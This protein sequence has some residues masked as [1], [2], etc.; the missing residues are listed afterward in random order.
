MKLQICI[1]TQ[2]LWN[3]EKVSLRTLI[4]NEKTQDIRNERERY[5]QKLHQIY[6]KGKHAQRPISNQQSSKDLEKDKKSGQMLWLLQ[7][8]IF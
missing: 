1:Q 6:L 3:E 5:S 4:R 8:V 2:L 7:I